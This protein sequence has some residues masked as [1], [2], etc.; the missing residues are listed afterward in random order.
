M[1]DLRVMVHEILTFIQDRLY[2]NR[3]DLEVKGQKHNAA[4]LFSTL[5][6]LV[7][8]KI[9]I[10]GEPGL[11]KTTSAEYIGALLYRMPLGAVWEAEVS[12]HPEQTEEKIV[13]R[14]NLGALN[15]GEEEVVWS[16]FSVLP[17]KVVDEINRLPET[18][19]SLILNGVDRGN[20]SYLNQMQ[21]N[22]EYCLFATA[23]YQDR[24]TNTIVVPLLDRFDVMVESKHP[25]ANLSWMIGTEPSS[26]HLLRDPEREQAIQACLVDRDY[27]AG[28]EAICSAYG[29]AITKR[30]SVPTLGREERESIRN[31]MNALRFDTDASAF[32]RTFLAELSF[33]CKYGQKRTNEVC[34]E[35]C[36]YT[37]YLC[38]EV[39]T[40]PS[41]RLPISIRRYAQALAWVL[42][43]N[44]V[45]LEHIRVVLPY[46]CAHRLQWRDE[47]ESQD[48]RDDVMPIHRAREAVRQVFRRY[49][50]Q[51]DRIQ[52]AL[53]TANRIVKGADTQ[54]VQGEH[55]IYIEIMRDLGIE[56]TRPEFS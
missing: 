27:G 38:Y 23:N 40:C 4:L 34:G 30:L 22:D 19:Q 2:F 31:E 46:A 44:E 17:V 45:D 37:G 18:K 28:V 53:I 39:Q 48:R 55:P 47:G 13:G 29:D 15:R 49:T 16:A 24:G 52:S 3:A 20:W 25:G 35:G 56:P 51:S 9:L 50:E 33:C 54:P 43:D 7:G 26:A 14:P 21:I 42:G 8:G 11:G 12:G 36:H 32:V 41:N 10:V 5:T 6:G 1:A